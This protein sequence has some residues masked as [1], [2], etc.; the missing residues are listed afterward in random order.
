MGRS[1]P[2]SPR[3]SSGVRTLAPPI[4]ASFTPAPGGGAGPRCRPRG[5]RGHRAH[6]VGGAESGRGAEAAPQAEEEAGV[7]RIAGAGGLHRA[8][9][10]RGRKQVAAR[11]DP[12]T[13]ARAELDHRVA[14]MGAPVGHGRGGGPGPGIKRRFLLVH[15]DVVEG[16]QQGG[17]ARVAQQPLVPAEVP[18]GGDTPRAEAVDDAEP[19][20]AGRGEEREVD[21]AR[22]DAGSGRRQA[23]PRGRR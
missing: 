21:V 23:R 22:G 17:E 15:E 4:T 12:T 6:V 11:R 14:R 13:A 7:E 1:E 5:A 10:H 19:P 20:P 18:R 8:H 3:T 16:A 9:P 2:Q